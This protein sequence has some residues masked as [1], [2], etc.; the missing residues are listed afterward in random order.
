MTSTQATYLTLALGFVGMA[1]GFALAGEILGTPML[2]AAMVGSLAIGLYMSHAAKG[3]ASTMLLAV[4]CAVVTGVSA[5]AMLAL[6][7]NSLG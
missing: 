4:T 2:A 5:R 6:L 1:G 7:G 3:R